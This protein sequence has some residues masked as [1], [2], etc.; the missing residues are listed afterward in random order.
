[1]NK[2]LKKSEAAGRGRKGKKRRKKKKTNEVT[3]WCCVGKADKEAGRTDSKSNARLAAAWML[4]TE[5]SDYGTCETLKGAHTQGEQHQ[6]E[7][8]CKQL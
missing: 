5:N 4:V 7:Q 2:I 3:N 1:M 6:K 8:H